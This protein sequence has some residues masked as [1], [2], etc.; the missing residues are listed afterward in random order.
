MTDLLKR[1]FRAEA[2]VGDGRTIDLRMVPF[3][4]TA[5]VDDG[6]GA[7]E[8]EFAP[9]AFDGQTEHAHRVYMNFQHEKG[10]RSIVGKGVTME[11]RDDALYGS[12]RAFEDA[13]GDKALTLVREGV[14]TGASIE[15]LP[16]KSVRT[17]AG[18]VRRVKAH[19]DAVALCRVGA[20]PSAAVL[21]VRE[22]ELEQEQIL[23][24]EVLPAPIDPELVERLRAKGIVLPDRY[25]EAHPVDEGTPAESG[26]PD[27]D[28]TRQQESITSSE[29]PK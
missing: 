7:Y 11:R 27:D 24:A 4:E 28:G 8:E 20:Y 29:E 9:E 12:F 18:V 25:N 5:L 16:Q 3:N 26:T 2:S 17:A 23:D 14:L 22:Q 6:A 19:L 10:I 13:D 15:F 21:A 1:E